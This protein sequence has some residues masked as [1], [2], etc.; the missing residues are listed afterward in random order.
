LIVATNQ[1]LENEVAE[2]RFRCDLYYRLNVVE[3]CLP[4]L[5]ELRQLI[6]PL[7]TSFLKI[8]ATQQDRP[9]LSFSE[10]AMS[11]LESYRWPGNVRELR[12]VVERAAAMGI[13]EVIQLPDLPDPVRDSFDTDPP[14]QECST[15]SPNIL[16]W[17]RKRAE[18]DEL[19]SVLERCG[20]NRVRAARELGISRTALY[21]RLRR[22][23][24]M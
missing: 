18:Y 12:N 24:I 3:I 16:E 23:G 14:H 21:K 5:R 6:R 8:F 7:A 13:D 9:S 10:A 15:D 1:N 19:L 20:N 22:F 11:A 4:P 17:A 2:G